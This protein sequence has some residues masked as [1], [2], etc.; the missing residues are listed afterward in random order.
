MKPVKNEPS[1]PERPRVVPSARDA[2]TRVFAY[3]LVSFLARADHLRRKQ[4]EDDIDLAVIA[5]AVAIAA[6]DPRMRDPEFVREFS[7]IDKVV[8]VE[9][10]RG[11][12]ALS[13][14]AATGIPRETARRK[15]KRLLALGVLAETGRGKYV[16]KPGYLQTPV[17]RGLYEELTRATVRF[18]NDCFDQRILQLAGA[19]S[20]QAESQGE[21]T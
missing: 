14:A 16:L 3:L 2:N 1:A 4:F 5:E 6:I 17:M 18:V 9:R 19:S 15:I 7:S 20:P 10:Q 13:I 21:P 8:G 11:V 12:N